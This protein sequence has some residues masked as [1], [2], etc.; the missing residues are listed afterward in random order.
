MKKFQKE[1]LGSDAYSI[2]HILDE[3]FN[4]LK[5]QIV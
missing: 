2:K 4:I 5:A 1:R 3:S